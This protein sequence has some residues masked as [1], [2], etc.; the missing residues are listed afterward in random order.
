MN[1]LLKLADF[2]PDSGGRVKV[3]KFVKFL[4][5]LVFVK[6]ILIPNFAFKFRE[7]LKWNLLCTEMSHEHLERSE[8]KMVTLTSGRCM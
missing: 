8:M 5:C 2:G 7:W 1:P 3:R 4:L 6:F